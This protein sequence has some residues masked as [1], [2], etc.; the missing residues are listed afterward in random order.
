VK[1]TIDG[2][3]KHNH[4]EESEEGQSMAA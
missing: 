3:L 1:G 4:G 2:D